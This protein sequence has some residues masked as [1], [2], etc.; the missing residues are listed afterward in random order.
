MA[1]IIDKL[2]LVRQLRG[3]VKYIQHI[4]KGNKSGVLTY[5]TGFGKTFVAI[6]LLKKI[7]K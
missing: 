1:K 4:K 2:K 6:L 3:C 7:L 5:A